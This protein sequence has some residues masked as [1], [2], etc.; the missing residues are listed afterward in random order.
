MDFRMMPYNS[1]S[2]AKAKVCLL[3]DLD[4][5]TNLLTGWHDQGCQEHCYCLPDPEEGFDGDGAA[6]GQLAALQVIQR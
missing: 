4:Q 3:L 1:L 2:T 6:A 5:N